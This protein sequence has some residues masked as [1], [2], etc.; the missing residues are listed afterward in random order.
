MNESVPCIWS[1]PR[2]DDP[3][4]LVRVSHAPLKC[5]GEVER[6]DERERADLHGV[7]RFRWICSKRAERAVVWELQQPCELS[8][9]KTCAYR[10]DE[11]N[12]YKC[13]GSGGCE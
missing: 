4:R 6:T 10:D 11:A 7:S 3:Y 1:E 8:E 9:P 2:A 13:E 12:R 5:A